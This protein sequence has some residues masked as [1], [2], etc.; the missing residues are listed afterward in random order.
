MAT[1]CIKKLIC[2]KSR[3]AEYLIERYGSTKLFHQ[4]STE[5]FVKY[6]SNFFKKDESAKEPHLRRNFIFFLEFASWLLLYSPLLVEFVYE[7]SYLKQS[8]L[9]GNPELF[10][11]DILCEQK[12]SFGIH[13][14]RLVKMINLPLRWL[15]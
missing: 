7:V 2:L 15:I 8:S 3:L 5:L 11:S 14:M 12:I 10:F 13:M 6:F 1:I 9:Y 4:Y